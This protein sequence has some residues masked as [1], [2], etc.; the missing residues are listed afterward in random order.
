MKF[1]YF[2]YQKFVLG[3]LGKVMK[4]QLVKTFNIIGSEVISGVQKQFKNASAAVMKVITN[5][6]TK[7][8]WAIA[9]E[10]NYKEAK[11]EFGKT[12]SG[13]ASKMN[14]GS[15][16]SSLCSLNRIMET[17]SSVVNMSIEYYIR[18]TFK[19]SIGLNIAQ[20]RYLE[21]E[22]SLWE[23]EYKDRIYESGRKTTKERWKE[24]KKK[25]QKI[26][27]LYILIKVRIYS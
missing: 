24:N 11:K 10:I 23:R 16:D 15:G 4:D 3:N 12:L 6:P 2:V 8:H 13:C 21:D 19:N 26:K 14:I 1:D 27:L 17:L 18:S 22:F 9:R 7:D 5:N 20:R 25:K